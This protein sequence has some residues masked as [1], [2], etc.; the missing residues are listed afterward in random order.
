MFFRR[1]SRPSFKTPRAA[2][3]LPPPSTGSDGAGGRQGRGQG[4]GGGQDGGNG[5]GGGGTQ[6]QAP[7]LH[8]RRHRCGP[9]PSG[10]GIRAFPDHPAAFFPANNHMCMCLYMCLYMCMC[11]PLGWT[12]PPPAVAV[13]KTS[14]KVRRRSW[15]GYRN[16][17]IR[18]IGGSTHLFNMHWASGILQIQCRRTYDTW[19][20]SL[21]PQR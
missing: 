13:V 18:R 1:F 21:P 9:R 16:A 3:M 11:A 14:H 10:V 20:P 19:I 12:P 4:G 8:P 17:P 7:R 15:V 6:A 2:A 5:G